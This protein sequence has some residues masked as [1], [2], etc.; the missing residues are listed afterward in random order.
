[1]VILLQKALTT[2]Y[3]C[4]LTPA[5]IFGAHHFYLG[6]ILFGIY[7]LLTLGGFGI[8]WII[9]WIRMPVLVK[10]ANE[11]ERHLLGNRLLITNYN[12]I[13]LK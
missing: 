2:A 8:G 11:P 10:R 7:Y 5:G 1:M 9:D 12:Q 4:G 13:V 6:R 3:L